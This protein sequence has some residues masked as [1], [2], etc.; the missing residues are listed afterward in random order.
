MRSAFA[1]ISLYQKMDY[2]L[3][4]AA[5][6]LIDEIKAYR[7]EF[8]DNRSSFYDDLSWSDESR[9]EILGFKDNVNIEKGDLVLDIATG[10]GQFLLEMAKV[11]AI[12]FGLDISQKMLEQIRP[13]IESLMLRDNIKG[14]RVGEADDLPYPDGFFDLVT[15]I[16]MFEYYPLEYLQVVL[17]EIH[18]VLKPDGSSFI[19]IADP[20]NEEMQKREYIYKTDLQ[21]F[22]KTVRNTGFQIIKKNVAGN[23][24]QYLI[25]SN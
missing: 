16:G 6:R 14:L 17:K 5:K 4:P 23:M 2:P 7:R 1:L 18:R 11:G 15:C 25:K 9:P 22:G 21:L 10:T 24:I 12:C 20:G 19:D 13:K 8:Y 3:M